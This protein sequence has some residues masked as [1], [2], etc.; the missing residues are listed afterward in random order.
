MS[1][2]YRVT[3][4]VEGRDGKTR[5][6]PVGVMFPQRDGAKS[7]FTLKLDFPVGVTELVL[8]EPKDAPDDDAE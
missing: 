7:A 5:F 3:V 6:R 2:Y 8:F 4:P 1:T